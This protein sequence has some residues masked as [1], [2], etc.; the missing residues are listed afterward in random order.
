MAAPEERLDHVV[1]TTA[2]VERKLD[3]LHAHVSQTAHMADREQRIRSLGGMWRVA[4]DC[5]PG[6]SPR[7][8]R[9][10]PSTDGR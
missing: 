9:S 7:R 1:D 2:T 4:S 10:C 6:A 5:P 8:S 3:A